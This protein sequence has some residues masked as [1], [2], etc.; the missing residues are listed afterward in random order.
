MISLICGIENRTQMH[1]FT[2]QRET[3]RYENGV[4]V[5]KGEKGGREVDWELGV[6]R[7]ELL[8]LEG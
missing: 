1:Q 3:H 8:H 7:C 6:S 2:E 5:T 4:V